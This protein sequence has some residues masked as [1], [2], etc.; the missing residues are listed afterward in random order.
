MNAGPTAGNIIG[1]IAPMLNVEPRF[2]DVDVPLMA[3]Y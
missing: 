2:D 3:A 1:R